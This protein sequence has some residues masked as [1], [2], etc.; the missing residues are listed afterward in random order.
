[1]KPRR[2]VIM[3]QPRFAALAESGAKCQ[4]LRPRRKRQIE[5][6]DIVDLR[7]WTGLP[8]R[9]KQRQL[10]EATVTR[11]YAANIKLRRDTF[12]PEL[13][14]ETLMVGGLL[15]NNE[16]AEAGFARADGFKNRDEF[17]DFFATNYAKASEFGRHLSLNFHGQL[18]CWQP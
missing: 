2:H 9:S 11:V 4:T 15:F 6:G 17:F 13:S 7:T 5:V 16:A 18:I 10:R 1:M 8:Y 14:C 12:Y 3:F